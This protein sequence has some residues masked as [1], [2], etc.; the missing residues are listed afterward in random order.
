VANTLPE[1]TPALPSRGDNRGMD[2]AEIS[3]LAHA[4]HPIAAPVSADRAR[5]LLRRL[6]PPGGSRVADLGCGQ[7]EWLLTLLEVASGVSGAGVDSAPGALAAAARS[8]ARRGLSGRVAWHQSDATTWA[9]GEFAAVLCVGASHAFGG[10][11][12]TLE[13]IRGHLAPGGRVLFG[14]AIWEAPPTAAAQAALGA[15]ASEFP[16]L[17]GLVER[18]EKAGFEPVGGHVSTR[19]EW[20]DYEWSW[21]GT[22][23]EW[24]LR[25]PSGDEDRTE[26]LAAARVHRDEWLRGYRNQLGFVTLVLQDA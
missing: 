7:G 22:L 10:L 2:R 17:A 19:E 12:A 5:T 24:A 4:R 1:R 11:D 9:D 23:A 3:R 18:I 13:A 6:A 16:D 14:D 21:T 25:R 8:A 26:A 20:D 15:G